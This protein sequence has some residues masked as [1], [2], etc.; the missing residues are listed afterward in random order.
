MHIVRD[1]LDK[2]LID[3]NWQHMGRI[4]GLVMEVRPDEQPR[5]TT[6]CVGG[7]VLTGRLPGFVGRWASALVRRF[8]ARRGAPFRIPWSRVMRVD[9]V[10]RVDVNSDESGAMAS[11][12]WVR[13]HII[14]HIPGA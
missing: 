3:V 13:D 12:Q 10:I 7:T 6:I 14:E 2:E 5:I 11:S 1:L 4:D 8:G 9:R